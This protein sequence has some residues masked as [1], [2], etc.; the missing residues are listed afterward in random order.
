MAPSMVTVGAAWKAGEAAGAA[1]IS[2]SAQSGKRAS[3]AAVRAWLRHVANGYSAPSVT[4]KRV[5]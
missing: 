1:Y 3:S 2:S 4:W 5:V